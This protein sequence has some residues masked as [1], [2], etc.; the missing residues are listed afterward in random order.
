VTAMEIDHTNSG[1][2]A[3]KTIGAPALVAGGIG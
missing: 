1:I 3:A 2:L